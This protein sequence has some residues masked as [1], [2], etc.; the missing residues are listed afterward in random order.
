MAAVSPAGPAP[1]TRQSSIWF[2]DTPFH[3]D[4]RA[5]TFRRGVLAIALALA[6]IAIARFQRVVV[7]L[8][9]GA[10]TLFERR[11]PLTHRVERAI[12]LQRAENVAHRLECGLQRRVGVKH[13]AEAHFGELGLGCR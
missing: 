7:I 6:S 3:N 10:L 1:T 2:P 9:D 11:K 12:L 5:R 4:R 8:R 13:R